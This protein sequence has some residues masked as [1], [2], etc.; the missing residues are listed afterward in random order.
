MPS[1]LG[2]MVAEATAFRR[3]SPQADPLLRAAATGIEYRGAEKQRPVPR[4]LIRKHEKVQ[5]FINISNL[6]C[7]FDTFHN[8]RCF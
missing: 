7:F 5:W 1:R 2:S 3:G 8:V 4:L 6:F